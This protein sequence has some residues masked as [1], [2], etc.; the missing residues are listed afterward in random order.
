MLGRVSDYSVGL[1]KRKNCRKL[2]FLKK[3]K[4]EHHIPEPKDPAK[5][6]NVVSSDVEMKCVDGGVRCKRC[7]RV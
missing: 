5:P 3:L 4:R 7:A 2:E 6:R 1:L